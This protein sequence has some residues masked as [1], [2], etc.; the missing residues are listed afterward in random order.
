MRVGREGVR[1]RERERKRHTQR[2]KERGWGLEGEKQT[3]CCEE[4]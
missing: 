4:R 1:E 2:E 3:K